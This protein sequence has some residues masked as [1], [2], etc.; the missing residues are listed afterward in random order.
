MSHMKAM[1][2]GVSGLVLQP[3][4][5]KFIAEHQPWAFILFARNIGTAEEVRNLTA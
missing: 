1:I 3:D 5:K 4:E 2:V